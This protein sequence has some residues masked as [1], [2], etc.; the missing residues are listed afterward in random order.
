MRLKS[1]SHRLGLALSAVVLVLGFGCS[2]ERADSAATA[3]GDSGLRE[4][5]LKIVASQGQV[6]FAL[7][8]DE[9]AE[10][11]ALLEFLSRAYCDE[12]RGGFCRVMIWV[13]ESD[14]P[15]SLPMSEAQLA[16]Q[17]AQYNRNR[18]TGYDCFYL[19]NKGAMVDGSR[20]AGCT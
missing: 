19:M 6:D 3:E 7:V 20:S 14:A 9:V 13:D 2:V 11:P 4:D 8:P 5:R 12:Q 18:Q 17:I 10:D 16:A 1:C 15:H